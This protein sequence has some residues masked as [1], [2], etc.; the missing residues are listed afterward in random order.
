MSVNTSLG[1]A[2]VDTWRSGQ[3]LDVS[4]ARML[5]PSTDQAAYQ[6]QQE[7][8]RSL[9]WFSSGR[10]TAWKIG[11]TVQ[12]PTASP[13]ADKHVVNSPYSM[14][15]KSRHSIVGIEVELALK[16]ASPLPDGASLDESINAVGTVM[17]AIEICDV[18][19]EN[20]KTLPETFLLADHQMNRCLIL[21]EAV[22]QGW[23]AGYVDSEITLTSNQRNVDGGPLRHPLGNPLRLLPWLASHVQ[24]QY[25]PGLQA[26]DIITTGTWTGILEAY[27]DEMIKAHF[28]EIGEVS[29]EIEA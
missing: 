14:G 11:G 2:L 1:Q 20:W 17:A 26:G 13:I 4:R 10:P 16:L 19:A 3:P 21:G 29:L 5:S 12:R 24:K 6:V 23:K 15:Y 25:P 28:S 27:P 7:V 9:G 22:T 8:A 18:R